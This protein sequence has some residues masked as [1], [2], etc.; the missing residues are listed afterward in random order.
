MVL[1]K[2][3]QDSKRE[4]RNMG[5]NYSYDTKKNNFRP[6][7]LAMAVLLILLLPPS[8]SAI[9]LLA[10][11][12]NPV[13][14]DVKFDPDSFK[15]TDG[16]GND[17]KCSDCS[18]GTKTVYLSGNYWRNTGNDNRYDVWFMFWI[19][20]NGNGLYDSGEGYTKLLECIMEDEL[21]HTF[22]VPIVWNCGSPITIRDPRVTW[23]VSGKW[24]EDCDGDSKDNCHISS[25]YFGY[26]ASYPLT[27]PATPI[28]P[29][30][31]ICKGDLLN[32]A[33]FVLEGARCTGC[34]GT[35]TMTLTYSSVDTNTP[36]TY[37]YTVKCA[38]TDCPNGVISTGYVTVNPL[39]IV[40]I[41]PQTACEGHTAGLTASVSLC[42]PSSYQWYEGD[43]VSS[44][45]LIVGAT[46]AQYTPP[47]TLTP[48]PHS[49]T[50]LVRCASGCSDHGTGILTIQQ[51]PTAD[52]GPNQIVC[53]GSSVI[54]EGSANNYNSVTWSGG[55]GIFYPN[56]NTLTAMYTPSAEEVASGT[57]TLT[58]TA[59][60]ISPCSVSSDPDTIVITMHPEPIV[61]AGLDQTICRGSSAMLAGHADHY[62]TITWTGGAGTFTPDAHTLTATYT[63][64]ESEKNTGSVT[65]TLTATG[66][67][68]CP[69]NDDQT[70]ITIQGGPTALAPD[71]QRIC[72]PILSIPLIGT[73]FNFAP[74]GLSWSIIG[75]GPGSIEQ[76]D[77]NPNQATYYTDPNYYTD[78][79]ANPPYTET[80]VRFTAAG[81]LPCAGS[82]YDDVIIR[83][84][85]K[86]IA[87]ITVIEP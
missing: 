78:P 41:E 76:S 14:K 35:C 71:D 67:S 80:T 34:S 33:K 23:E 7:I 17:I 18:G 19:D 45:K 49:Y 40:T 69:D 39:P 24:D 83:V 81:I 46:N 68:P 5:E 4:L 66:I 57:V 74:N 42:T 48:G 63:P 77:M 60:A 26:I 20:N 15:I 27:V 31:A 10:C 43:S 12:W 50:C 22:S 53:A 13:A 21:V 37:P 8:S 64:T 51:G 70:T 54:L 72:S 85:Q 56:P 28:A 73:A 36:G 61:D 16:S 3:F 82:D 9:D 79:D 59:A 32:D 44:A 2:I 52:A 1:F 62:G 29:N 6:I 86:P 11:D 25:K 47:T 30:F 75:G 38:N 87:Y 58:L 55:K 84:D 65:L